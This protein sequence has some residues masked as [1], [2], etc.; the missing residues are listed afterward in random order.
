MTRGAAALAVALVLSPLAVATSAQPRRPAA[1]GAGAPAHGTPKGWTFTLPAGDAARGR[2]AFLRFDCHACHEVQGESFPVPTGVGV[3]PELASMA[4][5]HEPEFFAEAII[6]P[7]KVVEKPY[8]AADG[9]SRMPAYNDSMTVQEMIDL[10]A[11]LRGLRPPTPAS[12]GV[13]PA[14]EHHK[15]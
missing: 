1:P 14:E 4:R 8:R 15:H 10:V 2:E 9:T 6:N 11:Y 7:N 3:G 5:H 12:P 13:K